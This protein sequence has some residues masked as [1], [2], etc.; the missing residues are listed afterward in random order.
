MVHAVPAERLRTSTRAHQHF[1]GL[2]R[3]SEARQ[4]TRAPCGSSRRRRHHWGQAEALASGLCSSRASSS[5]LTGQDTER[6]TFSTVTSCS[7]FGALRSPAGTTTVRGCSE[8]CAR[9]HFR[10]SF[11]DLPRSSADRP[12]EWSGGRG[13]HGGG[14]RDSGAER[15][16][17]RNV[18]SGRWSRWCTGVMS[19]VPSVA[20]ATTADGT[21]IAYQ[22]FGSG[23]VDVVTIPPFAQNIELAWELPANR[24]MLERMG[25][26]HA[27]RAVR[28]RD[29]GAWT[30]RCR[31][32]DS[33]SASMT[34]GR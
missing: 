23:D 7:M 12:V 11:P 27:D 26:L 34:F 21:S 18:R 22:S 30:G 10:N 17:E 13:V 15:G 33:I 29:T 20:Y 1:R 6:G 25:S 5:R 19:S 14:G 9:E 8:R 4:A 3:Q 31:C 2:H 28:Q 32:L 16:V 24:R